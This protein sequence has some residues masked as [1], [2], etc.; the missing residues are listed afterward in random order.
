MLR[1]SERVHWPW[2][3][4]E[5]QFIEKA[6]KRRRGIGGWFLS[7]R[8]SGEGLAVAM[9]GVGVVDPGAG[10]EEPLPQRLAGLVG[11]AEA[12]AAL[13]LGDDLLDEIGQRVEA[14]PLAQVDRVEAVVVEPGLD[15]V[16]DFGG[17]ADRPGGQGQ[18]AEA[19]L[20]LGDRLG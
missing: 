19:L 7:V 13:Q 15:L 5:T 17:R 3:M 6:L 1:E 4:W 10:V 11:G 18:E 14:V 9:G 8:D 12:A 20:A 16:G 2:W